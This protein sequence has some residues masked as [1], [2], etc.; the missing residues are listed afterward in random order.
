MYE[1]ACKRLARCLQLA[2]GMLAVDGASEAR[3]AFKRLLKSFVLLVKILRKVFFL[4]KTIHT[5]R[6]C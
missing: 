4:N 5:L 1:I 2:C 3:K 6:N